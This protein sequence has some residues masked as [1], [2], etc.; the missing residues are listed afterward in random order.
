MKRKFHILV[1]DD[2]PNVL[3]TYRLILQ[4]QGYEVSAALSSEEARQ[5]LTE[6]AIDLLLCDLSLEKQ[7]SGFDVID[8]AHRGNPAMPTVLLTG[9]ATPEANERADKLGIPVLFKPIDIKELLE[10]ISG[11]L[12]ENY[13]QHEA[14]C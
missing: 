12:R 5:A 6:K 14:A 11:L 1:V 9:Y 13:E 7:E 3:V 2:E 4:Q 10:T 8:F